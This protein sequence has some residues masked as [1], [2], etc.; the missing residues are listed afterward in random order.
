MSISI[1]IVDDSKTARFLIRQQVEM[2]GFDQV[3]F[4]ESINGR[5][6]LA[7]LDNA[8]AKLLITDYKMPEM[9]GLELLQS[10]KRNPM[11]Q[12][13]PVL[14]VTSFANMAKIRELMDH[15]AYAV[16]RKPVSVAA[17]YDVLKPLLGPIA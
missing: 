6:A 10:I 17:L 8:E 15:G 16:L 2:A 3:E 7:T 5:E 12:D 9:D 1:V 4:H 13:L 11:H 14:V